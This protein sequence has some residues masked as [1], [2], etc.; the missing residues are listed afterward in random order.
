MSKLSKDKVKKL[1]ELS[2]F[3]NRLAKKMEKL[4]TFGSSPRRPL[5]NGIVRKDAN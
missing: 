1:S 5:P 4:D 3:V 2:Y